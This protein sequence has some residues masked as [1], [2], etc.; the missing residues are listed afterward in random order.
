MAKRIIS[1]FLILVTLVSALPVNALEAEN[2]KSTVEAQ[3]VAMEGENSFG[4][5][6][7]EDITA[8]QTEMDSTYPEGYS[9]SDLVIEGSTATVTY[10]TQET[11]VLV[12]AVY[13]EDGLRLL[14][15][16][17]A[18][19]DAAATEATL[20]FEGEMP[21]YFYSKAYLMDGDS[22]APLCV[23]FETPMYTQDMQQLLSSTVHDYD[24]DRVLNLDDDVTTNFAVYAD[25]TI[26][27]EPA[28]GV[29]MV[30]G[31][32]DE[33]KTYVIKHADE[34]ISGL[35]VGDVFVYPY[36]ESD[37]LIVKVGSITVVGTTVTITGGD[38]SIGEVFSHI[39]IETG[40]DPVD[41]VYDGTDAA[42]IVTYEGKEYAD[43]DVGTTAIDGTHS[44][45]F[46]DVLTL[47]PPKTSVGNP[48]SKLTIYGRLTFD[49]YAYVDYYLT[50]N[51][52]YV[53]FKLSP[54]MTV[55]ASISGSFTGTIPLGKIRYIIVPG[56]FNVDV[57]WGIA[58][59]ITSEIRYE[60]TFTSEIVYTYDKVN[61]FQDHST[62]PKTLDEDLEAE[63]TVSFGIKISAT[64]NLLDDD[65]IKLEISFEAGVKLV[66]TPCGKNYDGNLSQAI[67]SGHHEC[68]ECLDIEVSLYVK[69]S[70]TFKILDIKWL[71][72]PF[73]IWDHSWHLLNA[74]YSDDNKEFGYGSCPNY[75]CRVTVEVLAATGKPLEGVR[76][77]CSTDDTVWGIT[78]RNGLV[79]GY[80]PR[81][82]TYELKLTY[83][84]NDRTA[85]VKISKSQKVSLYMPLNGESAP[86][87]GYGA[88]E[89]VED[90]IDYE[91]I[92]E[93]VD[94]RIHM[95]YGIP[96][97]HGTCG[98]NAYW[99]L[100]SN[101][102]LEIYGT[103]YMSNYSGYEMPW[104]E[105][106]DQITGIIVD[107]GITGIGNYAFY[108]CPGL[109]E[110]TV[111][112]SVVHIGNSAFGYCENLTSLIIGENV[113]SMG[114]Y[115]FIGCG[116]TSAGP[117]GSGCDYQFGW[118]Y[119]IPNNAFSHCWYLTEVTLPDS[120][121]TIGTNAFMNC[122]NLLS[123]T[124]PDRV[125][126]IDTR[127]FNSCDRL[128]SVIIPGSVTQIGSCAFQNC[129]GLTSVELC[130]GV[131]Q[132]G[133][134]A[135]YGCVGLTS[136]TV[137]AS[138][139][140]IDTSAFGSCTNLTT[141]MLCD[142]VSYIS[143]R[144]FSD[145]VNL[146]NVF[147]P[148]SVEYI[149][150]RVFSGCEKLTTAGPV[151][152]GCN[153]EFGWT[154]AIPEEMF[155][156]NET[157]VSITLPDTCL[158][159]EGEAF[160]GC[161]ALKSI[162]IP[163]SVTTIGEDAFRDCSALESVYIGSGLSKI[164][165][166]TFTNCGMLKD[167]VISDGV[168]AIEEYAFQN[169]TSLESITIPSSVLVMDGDIFYLCSSLTAVIFEGDAPWFS[170]SPLKNL[171][172]TVYY[173]RGNDTWT[174]EVMERFGETLTWVAYA[175]GTETVA[176]EEIICIA[177]T[178][179]AIHGGK[180]S[181]EEVDGSVV[182]TA[183]YKNLN[184]G[185]AYTFLSLVSIDV[186]NP[187]AAD[188]LL[189]IAQGV[190]A[191][192]GTLVFRYVQ[193][194]ATDPSYVLLCGAEERDLK[195]AVITFPE[196]AAD[197]ELYAVDPVVEYNGEILKEGIDYILLGE[198]D[199]TEAGSYTC[200]VSGIGDY[201]GEV[202]CSYTVTE[203]DILMG[204]VNRDRNVDNLDA[205]LV[206][207]YAAGW[208]VELDLAAADVNGDGNID[209]LDATLI[210]QYAAGWDVAFVSAS[211]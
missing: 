27:I 54:T 111:P 70:G 198:V 108:Q 187:L 50:L 141:V 35:Q 120:L 172:A 161:T 46:T 191:E 148:S 200:I 55:D 26:L 103:G 69:M 176:V 109:T 174:E 181:A 171:T 127:A 4:M 102:I 76:V 131:T 89:P 128:S 57:E 51:N 91:Q 166:W 45:N 184:P 158:T 168:R 65:V 117:I 68:N 140:R 1:T 205:T 93:E 9:V 210:L 21:E 23:N 7:S 74:Y 134:M 31:I 79:Y 197:G 129:T 207:Q 15:S 40:G 146:M 12:V 82:E 118:T 132:I 110:F 77:Y 59:E 112:S 42:E 133:A 163:D 94:P 169:C 199:Y 17:T 136:I 61:G 153:I 39:K 177:P 130:D 190:A 164:S 5:L 143:Q 142:G 49:V 38:V 33:T 152:S 119:R 105:Y 116:F 178:V 3:Y 52:Q 157:L 92:L 47:G 100:Y 121:R 123:V 90:S 188:N 150:S 75:L 165:T 2:T 195:D 6:L 88:T 73:D 13:T 78:N 29:N 124:I 97:V 95:E 24:A 183:S 28:D 101:G 62:T 96:E 83:L 196:M 71:E 155:Q 32:D 99:A 160:R 48:Y 145:C 167:V 34:S 8:T 151:D 30:T 189:Y 149:D 147:I 81:Y 186:E 37:M 194:V 139:T 106:M 16:A 126:S 84:S 154:E 170:T 86:D 204:D 162:A 58:S 98:D 41:S 87:D 22:L 20:T 182:K 64:P 137:P 67:Y 43:S 115:P 180:Y 14:N 56:V 206:L 185:Q 10:E 18:V 44:G 135:F 60:G 211:L 104:Y 63:G 19:V 156:Y 85:E 80:M 66:A 138:V 122:D 173:P 202:E 175:P 125:T 159:I 208:D 11:A 209:N 192:D 179:S 53:K 25:D 201:A 114:N 113:S 193:R 203:A 36:D 144:A 107:D 72:F